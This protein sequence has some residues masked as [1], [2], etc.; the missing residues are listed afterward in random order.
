MFSLFSSS[1]GDVHSYPVEEFEHCKGSC[2]FDQPLLFQ[3]S[4][5][6]RGDSECEG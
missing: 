1:F 2:L 5:R 6:D 3:T 4:L